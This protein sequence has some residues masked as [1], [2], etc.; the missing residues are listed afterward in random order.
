MEEGKAWVALVGKT[1][2][3]DVIRGA[4]SRI[5]AGAKSPVWR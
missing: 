5:D 2:S 4:G 3:W 1:G